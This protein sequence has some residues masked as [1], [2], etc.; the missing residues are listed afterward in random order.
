[1]TQT[2]RRVWLLLCRSS[3]IIFFVGLV[4]SPATQIFCCSAPF[5]CRQLCSCD[6]KGTLKRM[7]IVGDPRRF[8]KMPFRQ[9]Y[10]D[11]QCCDEL[12]LFLIVS[13]LGTI[14]RSGHK[15]GIIASRECHIVSSKRHQQHPKPLSVRRFEGHGAL[16]KTAVDGTL[17]HRRPCIRK[18]FADLRRYEASHRQLEQLS[19]ERNAGG[20][21]ARAAWGAA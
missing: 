4:L 8:C 1:M 14:G 9:D 2:D 7:Q 5:S 3:D 12:V 19:D 15:T 21:F 20:T 17:T 10:N 16:A 18:L 6:W 13:S 11:W